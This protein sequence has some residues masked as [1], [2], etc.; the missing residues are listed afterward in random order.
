MSEIR[1]L[2]KVGGED[3]F[4]GA[5]EPGGNVSAQQWLLQEAKKYISGLENLS[6][7]VAGG[8]NPHKALDAVNEEAKK[9]IDRLRSLGNPQSKQLADK[10]EQANDQVNQDVKTVVANPENRSSVAETIHNAALT[11]EKALFGQ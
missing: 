2:G 11:L 4:R 1:G 7:D 5:Q 10:L 9:I 3:P 6:K 8:G